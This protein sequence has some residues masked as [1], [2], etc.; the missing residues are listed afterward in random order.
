MDALANNIS[1]VGIA[2]LI[3]AFKEMHNLKTLD[4]S[5]TYGHAQNCVNNDA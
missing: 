3:N 5:C 4:L 2:A 1:H